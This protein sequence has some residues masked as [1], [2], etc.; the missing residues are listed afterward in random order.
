MIVNKPERFVQRTF[1]AHLFIGRLAVGDKAEGQY[2][3][4]VPAIRLTGY[5][6][7]ARILFG[8]LQFG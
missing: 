6:S 3:N 7:G 5:G 4:L 1:I 8:L 2:G